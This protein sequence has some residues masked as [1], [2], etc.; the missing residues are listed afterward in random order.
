LVY[1]PTGTRSQAPCSRQNSRK[2][3]GGSAGLVMPAVPEVDVELPPLPVL[4]LP[5]GGSALKFGVRTTAATQPDT[6]TGGNSFRRSQ[7]LSLF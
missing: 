2:R 5:A 4:P 1:I 7:A 6:A 3:L